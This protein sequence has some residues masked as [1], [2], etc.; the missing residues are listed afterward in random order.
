MATYYVRQDGNDS[1]TGL[2]ST[3]G[4]AWR[5]IQK[6]L[7]ATGIGSGDTVY[8][9]PGH[10]NEL[11]TVGGTYSAETQIIG[12]PTASQF[13]G[14]NA[15]FVRHSQYP[16]TNNT[17]ATAG[18]LLGGTGKSYLHFKNIYFE[19][20]AQTNASSFILSN[21]RFTKLTSCVFVNNQRNTS[22]TGD[23]AIYGPSGQTA[24][25]VVTNCI[26]YNHRYLELTGGLASGDQSSITNSAME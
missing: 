23:L 2:G 15:G 9:A 3:T 21:A 19:Y 22:V 11:V 4:L 20:A 8:I 5:T 12:D 17:A 18:Q 10:Y 26:F 25:T 6:A 13:I 14:V 16:A 7:G 24:N 1:N